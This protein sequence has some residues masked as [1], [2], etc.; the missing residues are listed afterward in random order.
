MLSTTSVLV[1]P[2]QQLEKVLV[3]LQ[4]AGLKPKPFN[5]ELLKEKVIH[6]GYVVSAGGVATDPKKIKSI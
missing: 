6:L 4:H 3:R 2:V 1:A 5:W